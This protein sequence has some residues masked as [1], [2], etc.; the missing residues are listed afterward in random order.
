MSR[1]PG[2][3]PRSIRGRPSGLKGRSAIAARRPPAALT[4][5]PLRP[6]A[7]RQHGQAKAYPA[8][9]RDARDHEPGPQDPTFKVSTVRGDCHVSGE[10]ISRVERPGSG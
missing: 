4:P 10:I 6:L 2:D 8:Q 1:G 5:E 3:A 7:G 9:L